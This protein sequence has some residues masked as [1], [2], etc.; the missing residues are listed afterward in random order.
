[1][2][3]ITGLQLLLDHSEQDLR[4]KVCERLEIPE[5]ALTAMEVRR[6]AVDAR[7]RVAFVYTV[8]VEIE[9]SEP[10]G[11]AGEAWEGK[12]GVSIAPDLGY[13]LPAKTLRAPEIR[14]VVVGAGPAGL[15][16]ALTLA[17]MGLCPL[18]LERGREVGQR[19]RDVLRFWENGELDPE[20][21]VAFGEGGAGTFSDGKLATQIKDREN[22]SRKVLIELVGVGA[23]DDILFDAKPHVG[24]DRLAAVVAGLRRRIIEMGGEVRFGCKVEDLLIDDGAIRGIRTGDDEIRTDSVI[25]AI[26]HSARDTFK[27]LRE[28]EV[29][30]EPKAFSIGVRIEH[31]QEMIDRAQ[32]GRFTG[33]PLLGAADYKLAHHASTGRTAYAFCMCPGG[34][35][36]AAASEPGFLVTNGMS[37]RERRA[38]NSNSAL[39]VSLEPRDYLTGE[40]DVLAG[41]E[42]QR[43]W[44]RLAYE[45]NGGDYLAPAQLVGDFL[46]GRASREIG[47]VQPSYR[48]GVVL[49]DLRECLPDWAVATLKE[50]LPAMACK[51]RGFARPDAIL[52]GVETRSSSPVRITRGDDSQSANIRGLYP[53]GEGA[54]YAGGIMSAAVDGIRAAEAVAR[55]YVEAGLAESIL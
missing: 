37:R 18:V 7:G 40:G 39:Q 25:L 13:R 23:P 5:A 49:G 9:S 52:T 6:R 38:P 15:F 1:M 24:T 16:A 45:M 12:A 35:V 51:L 27:M 22:R 19:A 26:G 31:P 48:P 10:G 50:A 32:Y 11:V 28:R 36:I 29:R 14:P 2:I 53:A 34:E 46:A 41:I 17:E 44:E 21:N 3:R 43:R 47:D 20:S 54:G 33:N 42:F 4:R 8:D 55:R 30:L